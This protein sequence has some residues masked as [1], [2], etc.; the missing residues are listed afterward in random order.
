MPH[1]LV[2]QRKKKKKNFGKK[3]SLE[4]YYPRYTFVRLY[5]LVN[6]KLSLLFQ[7]FNNFYS[8]RVSDFLLSSIFFW[9]SCS[10]KCYFIYKIFA[11]FFSIFFGFLAASY[12]KNY[13]QTLLSFWAN[14]VQHKEKIL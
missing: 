2:Q 1:S 12:R 8:V 3:Y 6:L 13:T 4:L 11:T 14:T 10:F 9:F 5:P 7:L